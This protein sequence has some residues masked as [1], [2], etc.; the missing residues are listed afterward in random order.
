MLDIAVPTSNGSIGTSFSPL[1]DDHSVRIPAPP[2]RTHSKK[3]SRSRIG[4]SHNQGS[5]LASSSTI[6]EAR[7]AETPLYTHTRS[8]RYAGSER[9]STPYSV[10][11]KEDGVVEAKLSLKVT[12]LETVLQ[13]TRSKLSRLED[14]LFSTKAELASTDARL[15]RVKKAASKEKLKLSTKLAEAESAFLENTS[16]SRRA[17]AAAEPSVLAESEHQLQSVLRDQE[18]STYTVNSTLANRSNITQAERNWRC[19]RL[20]L[21]A[22]AAREKGRAEA[23]VR[24]ELGVLLQRYIIENELLRKACEDAVALSSQLQDQLV[25]AG[26]RPNSAKEALW[27]LE[28]YT[29]SR[30][31]VEGKLR[32]QLCAKQALVHELNLLVAGAVKE[33]ETVEGLL[34]DAERSLAASAASRMDPERY[35]DSSAD[36]DGG[37]GDS[38]PL[39]RVLR[40]RLEQQTSELELALGEKAVLLDILKDRSSNNMGS[41]RI[42]HEASQPPRKAM[43]SSSVTS[44]TRTVTPEVS[45]DDPFCQQLALSLGLPRTASEQSVVEE[46]VR[47]AARTGLRTSDT[48]P[49]ENIDRLVEQLQAMDAVLPPE[50][51][52]WRMS[53]STHARRPQTVRERFTSR[54]S[55]RQSS[56]S[57][58]RNG[59]FVSASAGNMQTAQPSGSTTT[60]RISNAGRRMS[61]VQ[62]R[63]TSTFRSTLDSP[64]SP[65]MEAPRSA[66]SRWNAVSTALKIAV[67]PGVRKRPIEK[68]VKIEGPLV[69]SVRHSMGRT[70]YQ[71]NMYICDLSEP[72]TTERIDEDAKIQ[73]IAYDSI[74]NIALCI[75]FL[76]SMLKPM[77]PSSPH[78][79]TLSCRSTRVQVE[80]L[81]R[82]DV[83][84]EEDMLEAEDFGG[85]TGGFSGSPGDRLVLLGE[86]GQLLAT[87]LTNTEQ[88]E[89]TVAAHAEAAKASTETINNRISLTATSPSSP[90]S[91][92]SSATS[93]LSNK[94]GGGLGQTLE[95]SI[96]Q[97]VM[98]ANGTLFDPKD[99]SEKISGHRLLTGSEFSDDTE[100]ERASLA[101]CVEKSSDSSDSD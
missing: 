11:E 1:T 15:A 79:Y 87:G 29:D 49:E 76:P 64:Q 13:L 80:V 59:T 19:E 4:Q 28:G 44:V 37:V 84:S 57:T 62:Q 92:K 22:A 63:R 21:W 65:P 70:T 20:I 94:G 54:A 24:F 74:T 96:L 8:A 101:S 86:Q 58:S 85:L 18:R 75:N 42:E 89:A 14:D 83:F 56:A 82:L 97:G 5:F 3:R 34:A 47:L 91:V 60:A 48:V 45:S 99:K 66:R 23:R 51:L 40:R 98:F 81:K 95:N 9:T 73:I 32:R 61:T 50:V 68:D 33:R 25:D 27:R 35:R 39:V 72:G 77:F 67:L 88:R 41:S 38:I 69:M 55:T 7:R 71:V 17:K 12:S 2:P 30:S 93:L 36:I 90:L 31:G 16:S 26:V 53:S 78:I 6:S 43:T 100:E 10:H 46:V 52:K